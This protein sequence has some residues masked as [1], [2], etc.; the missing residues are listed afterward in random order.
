MLAEDQQEEYRTVW[1]SVYSA[2]LT[3]LLPPVFPVLTVCQGLQAVHAV[4]W[5]WC[6]RLLLAVGRQQ[7][8]LQVGLTIYMYSWRLAFPVVTTTGDIDLI[9]LIFIDLRLKRQKHLFPLQVRQTETKSKLK[10][11]K[12]LVFPLCTIFPDSFRSF[13]CKFPFQCFSYFPVLWLSQEKYIR[14][15][16]IWR[17]YFPWLWSFA[18]TFYSDLIYP[19]RTV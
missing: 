17:M 9:V 11:K 16:R 12:E 6:H 13:Y 1:C 8:Q 10:Q 14:Q 3:R 18:I 5:N 19:V 2:G 4:H 15:I 7:H